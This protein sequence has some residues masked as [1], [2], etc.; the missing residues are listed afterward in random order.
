MEQV[1]PTQW[2]TMPGNWPYVATSAI[3]VDDNDDIILLHRSD[4]VRSAK[5]AWSLPS[6]LAEIGIGVKEQ[7]EVEAF[8][9]LN[10]TIQPHRTKQLFFYE[11]I[12]PTDGFH[13]LIVVF[14]MRV[15]NFN[16]FI[17]R[18][19]DKHD[20]VKRLS[21]HALASMITEQ[22]LWAPNLAANLINNIESIRHY[23]RSTSTKTL[24]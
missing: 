17:N 19:P 24:I 2:K 1:P 8:E 5:N 6:G 10:L 20:E 21:I 7:M 14:G 3:I 4:K 16:D 22:E 23:V 18:E 11:N 12:T 13:W 9:E 15:K